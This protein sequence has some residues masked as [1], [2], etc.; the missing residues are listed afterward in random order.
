MS[1]YDIILITNKRRNKNATQQMIEITLLDDKTIT[2]I[3][4]NRYHRKIDTTNK[5]I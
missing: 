3:Q 1:I 4:K 5:Q 2:N